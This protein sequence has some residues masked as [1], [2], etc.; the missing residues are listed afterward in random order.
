MTMHTE[1]T[2]ERLRLTVDVSNVLAY[3]DDLGWH[4]LAPTHEVV[5]AESFAITERF[6]TV[7]DHISAS[8]IIAFRDAFVGK[9]LSSITPEATKAAVDAVLTRYEAFAPGASV[10]VR[11]EANAT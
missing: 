3:D 7:H 6:G 1:E 10:S 4:P 11:Y 9:P 8:T 2:I 5:D